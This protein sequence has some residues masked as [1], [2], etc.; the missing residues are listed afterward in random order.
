MPITF[1]GYNRNETLTNFPVLVTITNYNG[2]LSANGYDLRF[3]TNSTFSGTPLNYEIDTWNLAGSSF[4]WVQLPRLTNS[5][6]IYATWGNQS[7]FAQPAYSVNGATW[8]SSFMGVWHMNSAAP[9][10]DSTTN[11]HN[12]VGNSTLTNGLIGGANAFFGK[13]NF[14]ANS[15]FFGV[16]QVTLS[17]WAN[18]A[19]GG[20]GTF[21]RMIDHTYNSSYVLCTGNNPGKTASLD[22]RNT[23]INGTNSITNGWH[24]VSGEISGAS[25]KLYVDGTLDIAGAVSPPLTGALPL[26]FGCDPAGAELLNGSMDEVRIES[27]F[28]STNWIWATFQNSASNT[29]FQTYG[30]PNIA[31]QPL[32][33]EIDAW[34]NNG[35]SQVWVQVPALTSNTTIYATWGD[36]TNAAQPAYT[37]NGATWNS[38]FLGVWHMPNGTT[39]GLKDSTTNRNNGTNQNVVT[40]TAGAVDG[41]ANFNGTSAYVSLKNDSWNAYSNGTMSAWIWIASTNQSQPGFISEQDISVNNQLMNLSLTLASGT[42][43][44]SVQNY[45]TTNGV[46]VN[47]VITSATP[48]P[49]SNWVHCAVSSDG[50]FW[51]MYING[52][53]EPS[54][55]TWQYNHGE[56][57]NLLTNNTVRKAEIGQKERSTNQWP[58]PGKIDETRVESA[59]RS[60][61][62]VWAVYQNSASNAVFESYGEIAYPQSAISRM[63]ITFSGYN[64]AETLTNFP[65]L[66]TLSNNIN[67][68]GFSYSG[69]VY[70]AAGYDLRFWSNSAMTGSSLNYE[71]ESWNNSGASYVWVQVPTLTSGTTIYATWGNSADSTQPAYATN[72]A[73]WDSTFAG[74]WHMSESGTGAR[75]NSTTNRYDAA[76][77]GFNGSEAIPGEVA[78][79]CQLD[80]TNKFM[81]ISDQPCYNFGQGVGK[82]FTLSSWYNL[83]GTN[84]NVVQAIFSK[85]IGNSAATDYM[86]FNY[87]NAWCWGTGDA[88]ST[89]TWV[90]VMDPVPYTNAWHLI[91]A[92]L[93]ATGTITGTKSLYYDGVAPAGGYNWMYNNRA[94][95]QATNA[96]LGCQ[97]A[98]QYPFQGTLDETR[99]ESV[100]R[101]SNW[102]WAV[103]NNMASNAVFGAYGTV[104]T[105][106]SSSVDTTPLLLFFEQ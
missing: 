41:A 6:T 16:T 65:A 84:I 91:T 79:A 9:S 102:V 4:V 82:S 104:T 100:S 67:A 17:A 39:L 76:T 22:C 57:F 43:Y 89:G 56:W 55:T 54:N 28:R 44:L 50:G 64:K 30:A 85:R 38:G 63:P 5:A 7:D 34:T 94:T 13:T 103:Y 95:T 31:A 74:V 45:H 27:A 98:G 90:S 26:L 14:V 93:N 51:R 88:A 80:G 25:A 10:I 32:N 77:T 101:S 68:S 2:F 12:T 20:G 81:Q 21:G 59:T 23:G 3:W 92:T 106:G 8:D 37:T 53:M 62:W 69:F 73:T 11:I 35:T 97:T 48:L 105:T 86:L 24:L 87:T 47:N 33:Y 1:S 36:T 18:V 15:T 58:W 42:N 78:G 49:M 29:A 66:V 60:S 72:G 61:N 46:A 83:R 71:V 70:P 52:I 75:K 19:N 40:A 96:M 99:I